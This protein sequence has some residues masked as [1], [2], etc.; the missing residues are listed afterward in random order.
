MSDAE[1]LEGQQKLIADI[2]SGMS[3]QQTL[4]GIARYIERQT[5]DTFCSIVL[6]Q[7]NL[8]RRGAAPS[9][10]SS[11]QDALD[12]LIIGPRCGSCGT[13][14]YTGQQIISRD[15]ARD[16]LWEG[17]AQWLIDNYG[18]HACWATPITSAAG[19]VLGVFSMYR[20]VHGEP[21][22]KEQ[23]LIRTAVHLAALA[24]ER[25]SYE[26]EISHVKEIMESTSRAKSQFFA[27]MG[28]ELRTPLAAILG[29]TDLIS[30]EL[31]AGANDS[32]RTD[33]SNIKVAAQQL[34]KLVTNLLDIARLDI[35]QIKPQT[36]SFDARELLNR[37]V[38]KAAPI[39]DRKHNHFAFECEGELGVLNTDSALIE[40]VLEV[41]LDN[42]N[43]FTSDGKIHMTARRTAVAE[44]ESLVVSIS[45]TGIGMNE[46][47]LENLSQ[48]F[49]LGDPTSTRRHGGSGLGLAVAYG[50]CHLLGG[51][52]EVRSEVG[53]GSTFT[54][55]IPN[56]IR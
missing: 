36:E 35:G 50:L 26:T 37:I 47:Q 39:Y 18:M 52:V 53:K 38:A 51:S 55:S 33:L 14:A 32:L 21:S 22:E 43:K 25:S 30:E 4:Q 7:G 16:P 27:N 5:S 17:Y 8:L 49:F 23:A 2:A 15:V 19:Q 20:R 1:R 28:H 45:D 9:M 3:L 48:I 54:I 29:Y 40:R 10:P 11:F 42:A 46:Q 34:Q 13:A 56:Q 12:G 41:F 44:S 24:I 31:H 6:L